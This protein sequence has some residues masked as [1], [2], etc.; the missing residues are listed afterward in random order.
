VSRLTFGNIVKLG[1]AA[2]FFIFVSFYVL[3][4]G[5]GAKNKRVIAEGAIYAAM[6]SL[7]MILTWADAFAALLVLLSMGASAVRC[8]MLRDLWLPKRNRAHQQFSTVQPTPQIQPPAQQFQA[9]PPVAPPQDDLSPDLAWVS[10]HAKQNKHRLPP[11]S[12]VTILETC[13]T[14]DAVIDAERGQPTADARFEY[15]LTAMVREYLPSVLRGY[16]AIPPTMAYDKQPNGK[17]P[18]EELFEQLHLLS[19]Q[20]DALH[21]SRHSHTSAELTTTGNF[22]RQRFGHHQRGGFDFGID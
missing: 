2:L 14:L 20:A 1:L 11:E 3:I 15:E 18:N 8:Y 7:A 16:L 22:L 21:A 4:I 9:P 5:V 19:A 10:S 13:Q 17:T 12:Y 6:F